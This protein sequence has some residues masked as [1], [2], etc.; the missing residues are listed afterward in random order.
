MA[1]LGI[2]LIVCVISGC[3]PSRTAETAAP[4]SPML[5]NVQAIVAEQL[6]LKTADVKPESTFSGLGA[7]DLDFVEIVMVVEDRF[8]IV[9]SD[10]ALVSAA[11]TEDGGTLCGRLTI[12]T[13]A[14]IAEAAPKQRRSSRK[15]NHRRSPMTVFFANHK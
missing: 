10:D 13:F 3:G 15:T 14:T 6:G 7:D 5:A 9:I 2:L 8:G 4:H 1:R 12:R 11:G